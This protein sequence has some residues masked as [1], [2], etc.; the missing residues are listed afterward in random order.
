MSATNPTGNPRKQQ[1]I[2]RIAAMRD[3]AERDRAAALLYVR[4]LL[5]E[6]GEPHKSYHGSLAV[7]YGAASPG[8]FNDEAHKLFRRALAAFL[9]DLKGGAA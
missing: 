7:D 1:T 8:G 6:A 5:T 9:A 2:R 4:E 3:I